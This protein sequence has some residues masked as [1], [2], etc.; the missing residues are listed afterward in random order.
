MSNENA[1]VFTNL[2]VKV[3][4]HPPQPGQ[5]N[6][7]HPFM[8]LSSALLMALVVLSCRST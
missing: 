4:D 7:Q 8:A 3:Q 2:E 5:Q 6:L 1:K